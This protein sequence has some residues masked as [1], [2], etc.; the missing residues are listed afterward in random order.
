MRKSVLEWSFFQDLKR[1]DF[2]G[3]D[4]IKISNG[5]NIK[6]LMENNYSSGHLTEREIL[7]AKLLNLLRVLKMS[8]EEFLEIRRRKE[9]KNLEEEYEFKLKRLLKR[10]DSDYV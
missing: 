1:M 5:K 6:G 9:I 3:E 2:E 7:E 10:V 4:L 8:D